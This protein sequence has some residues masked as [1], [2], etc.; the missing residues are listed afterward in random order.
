MELLSVILE[1][2]VL[3]G[4]AIGLFIVAKRCSY[5]DQYPRFRWI[6]IGV[7]PMV[8]ASQAII[9]STQSA[10][11][12]VAFA[13]TVGGLFVLL[14]IAEYLFHGRSKSRAS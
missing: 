12:R 6:L 7:G 4:I 8:V 5:K 2:I 14:S 1:W 11:W 13:L 9:R 3:C 10:G